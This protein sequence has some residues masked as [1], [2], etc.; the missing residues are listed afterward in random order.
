MPFLCEFHG[1]NVHHLEVL[2]GLISNALRNN[3][4]QAESK[5]YLTPVGRSARH[6]AQQPKSP[7]IRSY[8]APL[9]G[10]FA[11]E[12]RGE[13]TCVRDPNG[14]DCKAGGS[15]RDRSVNKKKSPAETGDFQY[16]NY[17]QRA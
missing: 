3:R 13:R 11:E 9:S 15:K 4:L 10:G 14:D 6:Q 8:I 16:R 17:D 7:G 2:S 12:P 5:H 1:G